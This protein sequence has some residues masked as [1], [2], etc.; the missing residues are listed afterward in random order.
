MVKVKHGMKSAEIEAS[1]VADIVAN[2]N[3]RA[4]LGF[5]ENVRYLRC[6]QELTSV[7]PLH[8]GDTVTVEARAN[9]KA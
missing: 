8:A 2:E 7:S 9:S 3:L 6:G 4:L 5:G 1:T